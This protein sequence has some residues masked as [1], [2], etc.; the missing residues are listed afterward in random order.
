M[1][2]E[3]RGVAWATEVLG[4]GDSATMEEEREAFQRLLKRWHPD[5]CDADPEICEDRTKEIVE[6]HEIL[7]AYFESYR[8]PLD[9]DEVDVEERDEEEW[10]MERFGDDPIWGP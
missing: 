9:E 1:T 3:D 4:L 2:E 6:A 10:W 5:N 7:E 8:F